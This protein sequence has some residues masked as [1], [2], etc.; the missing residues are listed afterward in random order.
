MKKLS[1]FFC[2]V[3]IFFCSCILT[4]SHYLK[5]KNYTG[6]WIFT[7][8]VYS[9]SSRYDNKGYIVLN[10]DS[11]FFSNFSYFWDKDT[12]HCDS[13][14]G[15]WYPWHTGTDRSNYY[16]ELHFEIDNIQKVWRVD[17]DVKTKKFSWSDGFTTSEVEFYWKLA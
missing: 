17:G 13:L 15:T 10:S 12:S 14:T 5:L 3:S 1:V 7:E 2:V 4:D 16:N 11:T 9:E 8:S 6:K